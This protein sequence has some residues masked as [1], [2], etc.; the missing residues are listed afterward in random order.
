M[1]AVAPDK[2]G[3]ASVEQTGGSAEAIVVPEGHGNTGELLAGAGV[4]SSG[5][6]YTDTFLRENPTCEGKKVRR[7]ASPLPSLW[8]FD[9]SDLE[10]GACAISRQLSG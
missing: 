7:T 10:D 5:N 1:M 8:K 9:G 2:P 6:L 3:A 4:N